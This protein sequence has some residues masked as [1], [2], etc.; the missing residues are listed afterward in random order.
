M[1]G[2]ALDCDG[3]A[4][5]EWVLFSK[6][7]ANYSRSNPKH[8]AMARPESRKEAGDPIM[9]AEKGFR[10]EVSDGPFGQRAL[11]EDRT[12]DGRSR[13][14]WAQQGARGGRGGQED[15]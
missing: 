12:K 1:E 7:T 13:V 3:Q 10:L 11:A 6:N 9:E 4:E 5:K 15:S 14:F 8:G 2:P